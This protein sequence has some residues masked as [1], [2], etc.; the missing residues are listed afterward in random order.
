MITLAFFYADLGDPWWKTA[1]TEMLRSARRVMPDA[2]VVQLSPKGTSLHPWAHQLIEANLGPDAP[3][4]ASILSKLKGYLMAEYSLATGDGP[5]IF[6]DADVIWTAKP[7]I[8]PSG[9]VAWDETA[10]AL[11]FRQFYI[12]TGAAKWPWHRY[13]KTLDALPLSTLPADAAELALNMGFL[14]GDVSSLSSADTMKFMVHFPGPANRDEM[15]AFARSLDGGEPFKEMDP[16]YTPP[17]PEPPKEGI[18][19]DLMPIIFDTGG[20]I[21]LPPVEAPFAP[22]QPKVEGADAAE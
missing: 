5:V 1:V 18:N 19:V 15:I 8:L 17:A 22:Q 2:H 21:T 7:P 4:L 10:E 11:E 9:A 6:C 12:Q 20:K 3:D 16:S 13:V 14:P